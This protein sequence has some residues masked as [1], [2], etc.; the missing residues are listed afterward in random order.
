MIEHYLDVNAMQLA[1]AIV[2]G[3]LIVAFAGYGVSALSS[4]E[5]LA[6]FERY[7]LARQ[8]VLIASLQIAGSVGLFLGYFFRPLMVLSAGGFAVMMLLAVLTRVKIR[9]P[10]SATA[11]AF[12]LMCLNLFLVVSALSGAGRRS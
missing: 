8:R 9:D 12:V 4:H 2:Q 6:E 11:P 7:G 1:A 5:M 3:L 10:I